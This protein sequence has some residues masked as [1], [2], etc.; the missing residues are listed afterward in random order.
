MNRLSE[1]PVIVG[2]ILFDRGKIDKCIRVRIGS[3]GTAIS[4]SS[5]TTITGP[6]AV[7]PAQ[8]I[9][10]DVYVNVLVASTGSTK[11]FGFGLLNSSAGG[12]RIGFLTGISAAATGLQLPV[13]A[14]GTSGAGTYGVFLSV[15][16]TGNAPAQKSFATD[17]VTAKTL[18]FTPN[19]TDWVLF[20]ADVY[21]CYVDLTK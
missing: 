21:I 11:T 4:S 17:S 6:E 20:S 19:S 18:T 7:L 10:L 3:G 2:D 12:N 16:S 5:E 1:G 15:F 9:V 14:V 8:A 13:I